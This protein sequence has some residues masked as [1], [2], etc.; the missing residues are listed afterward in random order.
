M[1]TPYFLAKGS[2]DYGEVL[3]KILDRAIIER[4]APAT[5]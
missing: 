5:A 3:L 1:G 4:R 2:A